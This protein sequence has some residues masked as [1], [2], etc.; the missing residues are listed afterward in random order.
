MEPSSKVAGYFWAELNKKPKVKK[1]LSHDRDQKATF[2][3]VEQNQKRFDLEAA[4]LYSLKNSLKLKELL[5]QVKDEIW[6]CGV[7]SVVDKNYEI[8]YSM[9]D[10]YETEAFPVVRSPYVMQWIEGVHPEIEFVLEAKGVGKLNWTRRLVIKVIYSP[11]G[12]KLIIS[13]KTNADQYLSDFFYLFDDWQADAV[14]TL[15]S[16]E[17]GIALAQWIKKDSLWPYVEKGYK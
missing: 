17:L 14:N 12:C 5:E 8:R 9:E 3:L 10:Y 11:S 16:R 4:A 7:V 13:F 6:Y 1:E 2:E 15:L